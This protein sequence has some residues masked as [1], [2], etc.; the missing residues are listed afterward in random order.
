MND[1]LR[2]NLAV[3]RQLGN[4]ASILA[5]IKANAYGHGM[6]EILPALDD[7]DG[8]AVARLDE[9]MT[10]RAAEKHKSILLLGGAYT[11]L[12]LDI[13]RRDNISLVVHTREQ[14]EM[15]MANQSDEK[16][17]PLKLWVKISNIDISS[18]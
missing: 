14:I 17:L 12:E 8:F 4:K 6:T 10:L 16:K 7:A 2:N 3:V 5:V 1:H 15:L 13:C 11:A 9:A 18:N